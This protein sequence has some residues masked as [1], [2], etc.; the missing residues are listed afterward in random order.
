MVSVNETTIVY[1]SQKSGY[2][3]KYWSLT[4][5]ELEGSWLK[6]LRTKCRLPVASCFYGVQ[7]LLAG[8]RMW[9]LQQQCKVYF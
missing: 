1:N 3:A 6:I 8:G 2:L 9:K 4:Q 7:Q 5:T